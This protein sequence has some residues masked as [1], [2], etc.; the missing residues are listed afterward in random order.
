MVRDHST[1]GL[2]FDRLIHDQRKCS[3]PSKLLSALEAASL[4][5]PTAANGAVVARPPICIVR[6]VAIKRTS[7]VNRYRTSPV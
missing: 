5:E 2:R 1:Q 4:W 6:E 3:E 7:Q